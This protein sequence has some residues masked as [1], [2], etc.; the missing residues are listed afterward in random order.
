MIATA[1]ATVASV[2]RQ[3]IHGRCSITTGSAVEETAAHYVS[4]PVAGATLD[5][6]RASSALVAS[7]SIK[8]VPVTVRLVCDT[9]AR[10]RGDHFFQPHRGL[11]AELISGGRDEAAG[12]F[13]GEL[14][15]VDGLHAGDEGGVVAVG[16][17]HEPAGA[18]RK[19]VGHAW[20]TEREPVVVDDVDVGAESGQHRT[21]VAEAVQLG[22]LTRLTVDDVFERQL[23]ASGAVAGPVG[24][25]ERRGPTVADHAAV[26]AGV[27]QPH[28]GAGV[29][30]R[31][32]A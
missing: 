10:R 4:F 12:E 26:R 13:A 27:G 18:G 15:V 8:G 21:A 20:R 17:L 3:R 29:L 5:D 28:P 9:S 14:V 32:V 30:V 19:V 2:P 16:P 25:H 6:S 7:T 11:R 31:L 1:A 22:G 24:E 23:R